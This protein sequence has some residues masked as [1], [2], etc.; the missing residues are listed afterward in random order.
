MSY[1]DIT[2]RLRLLVPVVTEEQRQSSHEAMKIAADEIDSLRAER[3][4]LREPLGIDT[5]PRDGTM[6][7]L[8]VDYRNG[9]FPLEDANE[10]WTIGFNIFDSTGSNEWRFAGW[11]WCQDRFV[12]GSGT[13]IGWLP[14]ALTADPGAMVAAALE[15]AAEALETL[16]GPDNATDGEGLLVAPESIVRALIDKDHAA[17][18]ERV[19]AEAYRRGQEDAAQVADDF[20]KKAL[21]RV[22]MTSGLQRDRHEECASTSGSIA[23][24]IRSRGGDDD[25]AKAMSVLWE[26]TRADGTSRPGQKEWLDNKMLQY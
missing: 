11:D 3:D 25:Q 19:K 16:S 21:V 26:S 6:L 24:A 18:L 23:A 12:Q 17:A 1:M 4:R 13:V 10:A 14:L 22:D 7:R 9:D 20:H 8:L 15:R 5:A 2:E